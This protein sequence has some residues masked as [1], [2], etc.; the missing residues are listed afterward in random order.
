[1]CVWGQVP[2]LLGEALSDEK[3]REWMVGDQEGGEVACAA[4]VGGVT[5][6]RRE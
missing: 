2:S 4:C 6:P 3:L 5:R 1:V